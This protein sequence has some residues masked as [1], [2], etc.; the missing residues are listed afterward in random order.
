[1]PLTPGL[2]PGEEEADEGRG[3]LFTDKMVSG[4]SS[5]SIVLLPVEDLPLTKSSACVCPSPSDQTEC[6]SL[7]CDVNAQCVPGAGGHTCLCREGFTGDGRLC[8]G[9]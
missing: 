7:R 8:V 2:T 5:S 3:P 4:N 6:S 1:M 9:E